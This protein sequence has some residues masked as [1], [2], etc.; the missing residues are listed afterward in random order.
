MVTEHG[1][2]SPHLHPFLLKPA[3]QPEQLTVTVKGVAAQVTGKCK[4]EDGK[5]IVLLVWI[6]Y[7]ASNDVTVVNGWQQL[8]CVSY[9]R[10]ISSSASF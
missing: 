9:G 4:D 6:V 8:Y 2:W 1:V 3:D 7:I 5:K 10:V